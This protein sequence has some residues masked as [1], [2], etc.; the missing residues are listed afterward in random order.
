MRRLAPVLVGGL[1]AA[2]PA[3]AAA[4]PERVFEL[5][6]PGAKGGS[7]VLS[8]AFAT[9]D[10]NA[11]SFGSYAALGDPSHALFATTYV[12]RRTAEGWVPMSMQGKVLAPNPALVDST[13]TV[14]LSADLSAVFSKAFA[15]FG[16]G[17]ENGAM[18]VARVRDGVSTWVT[19]S[20]TLPDMNA[21]DSDVV[22]SSADGQRFVVATTKPMVAGV[23]GGPTQLYLSGPD[24]IELASRLPNGTPLGGAR[25]GNGRGF[26]PDN[27]A[28]SADGRTLF[29][30]TAT[31][32]S[33]LYV[34]RDG[35]TTLV[36]A[37]TTG[38]AGTAPSVYHAATD[39]GT[40]VLFS[41]TSQ[42]TAGAPVGG[43][44]Y[45]YDVEADDLRLVV[46]GAI[47]GVMQ[48]SDDL[49]VAYVVSTAQ[50]QSGTGVAGQPNLYRVTDGSVR[51][52]A[53]LSSQDNFGWNWGQ[54]GNVGGVSSDGNRLVFQSRAILAGANLGQFKN[55]IYRYDAVDD[56]LKCISC[57]PDGTVAAQGASLVNY[58]VAAGNAEQGAN[59][60]RVTT[61][62]GRLAVFETADA[63]LPEDQNALSDV[64][65]YDD[66]GL[67][68]ISGGTPGDESH[69]IDITPDGSDVFFFT[70]ANLTSDDVDN[71]YRDVYTA[72]IGGGFASVEA[73]CTA[74]T[75][76]RPDAA[77]TTFTP[78]IG[79]TGVFAV[80]GEQPAA[81]VGFR[82]SSISA[83][84]RRSWART[85]KT[86]LKVRVDAGA[87]I[88]ART[89][90]AGRTISTAR[91]TRSSAG[92]ST[93]TLKLSKSAKARLKRNGRLKL[94]V[95]VS[96]SGA[97]K[98]SKATV[99]LTA[100]K[101]KKAGR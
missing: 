7:D 13:E 63:L 25:L 64:Y 94:T 38:A 44:L 41:S 20:L 51:F 89:K 43:G 91:A 23:P 80:P 10:G 24:G 33:Q 32:V 2:M 42:L 78:V 52:V 39:D 87:K 96:V 66:D 99:T 101:T 34:H 65:G 84:S 88:T 29:F 37:D 68:L 22:G 97:P 60:S 3:T 45:R 98:A 15:P 9:A 58:N 59:P 5:A 82:V 8:A 30:S 6:S 27:R 31:G 95:T 79:S 62:D 28:I 4:A 72:R 73:P 21:V 50:L 86:R 48:T 56:A 75:C 85:G 14:G 100:P 49:S 16:A 53:T 55:G 19:P 17:D 93:L 11:V 69:A 81:K 67:H 74:G 71:G 77:A 61:A 47:S 36:S 26:Q 18:D 70:T 54:G 92:T 57:R 40:E 1:L 90:L 35:A 46:P 83:A 76:E 12:S